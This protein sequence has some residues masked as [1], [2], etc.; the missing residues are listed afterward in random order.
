[1][2]VQAAQID[3][4]LMLVLP[5]FP[6]GVG[7]AQHD[8]GAAP[9]HVGGHGNGTGPSGLRHDGCLVLVVAGVEHLMFDT[10]LAEPFAQL[11]RRFNG[12][13]AHQHRLPRLGAGGDALHHGAPLAFGGG[14]N[15]VSGFGTHHGQ[16]G[17][18]RHHFQPVYLVELVSF[19]H[20]GTGHAG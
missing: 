13:C 17:R 6:V 15:Q 12:G 2:T 16:V 18:H 20:S 11:F 19:G 8:V 14:K 10:A 9:R 4:L 1:M 5:T 3:Y 7:A